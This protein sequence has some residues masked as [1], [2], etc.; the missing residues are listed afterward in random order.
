MQKNRGQGVLVWMGN[1]T[2]FLSAGCTG[3]ISKGGKIRRGDEDS[4][5]GLPDLHS[6]NR[7]SSLWSR[8]G[9]QKADVEEE[10]REKLICP[11]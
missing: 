7:I 1:V 8:F 9:L 10:N 3:I 6:Q 4:A 11:S 2:R 5:E